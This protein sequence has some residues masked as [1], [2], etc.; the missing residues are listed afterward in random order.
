MQLL[1]PARGY[2][3]A[4]DSV[5]LAAAVAARP[6]QRV[7]DLGCGVGAVGLCLLARVPGIEVIGIELQPFL[8]ELGRRNAALN[9]VEER[10]EILQHDIAGPLPAALGQFDHVVSNPPYLAA[11]AADPSP[12]PLKAAA[13]VESTAD[14]ARWLAVAT[15][16]LAADG[17]LTLVHRRDRLAEIAAHLA[18]LGWGAV[19]IKPLAPVNRMLVRARHAPAAMH[20]HAPFVLHGADGDY[21]SEAEAILRHAEP[22]AF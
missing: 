21:T 5:L 2:R 14:L 18:A 13:T 11:A 6:G 3:V 17:T 9:R 20:E 19:A 4:V 16:Q 15:R 22:L 7:L 8:A 10:L 12:D 1:Q